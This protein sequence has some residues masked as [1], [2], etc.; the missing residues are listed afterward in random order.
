MLSILSLP[1]RFSCQTRTVYETEQQFSRTDT[2][3][4]PPHRTTRANA[5]RN[6]PGPGELHLPAAAG[7]AAGQ[8]DTDARSPARLLPLQ[9]PQRAQELGHPQTTPGGQKPAETGT[10]A[11][12]HTARPRV[13]GPS[14]LCSTALMMLR[15]LLAF[16]LPCIFFLGSTTMFS[17]SVLL[18]PPRQQQKASHKTCQYK[19][20]TFKTRNSAIST[21]E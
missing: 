17:V 9:A 3:L 20:D 6:T 14:S 16:L 7:T 21:Q 13:T 18:S 5:A 1:T 2:Y 12:R 4:T 10:G 8:T 19:E 11:R 15:G